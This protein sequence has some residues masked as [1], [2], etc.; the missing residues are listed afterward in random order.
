MSFVAVCTFCFQRLRAPEG[1]V[2]ASFQCPR[3]RN[4]FTL[5]PADQFVASKDIGGALSAEIAASPP[6]A[7]ADSPAEGA[8]PSDGAEVSHDSGVEVAA[9]QP[10]LVIKPAAGALLVGVEG[11]QA[12]RPTPTIHPAGWPALGLVA[13]AVLCGWFN[14]LFPLVLPLAALGCAV[15]IVGAVLASRDRKPRLLLSTVAAGVAA[16]FLVVVGLF[17]AA[18]GPAYQVYRDTREPDYTVMR[19]VPLE[20]AGAG[21]ENPDWVD[22]SR[23]ALQVNKVRVQ[24]VNAAVRPVEIASQPKKKL[25]KEKYL[26]L[27]FRAFQPRTGGEFADAPLKAAATKERPRPTLTDAGGKV[28]PP[29]TLDLR[30]EALGPSQKSGVFPVEV[31]DELFVFEA[32]SP[33]ADPLRLEVPAAPW[34]GAGAFRFLIPRSMIRVEPT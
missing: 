4:Y 19:S 30:E 14:R 18:L 12:A 6:P 1:A 32:P 17:P 26:V 34:G 16:A 27:R 31:A 3:C 25:S 7:A 5:A 23:F 22:A 11:R 33:G 20:G 28:Y 8:R 24:V 15:G 13:G 2:G 9:A 21:D 29:P 10:T